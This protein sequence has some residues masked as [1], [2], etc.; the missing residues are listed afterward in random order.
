[1]WRQETRRR[2]DHL[3]SPCF[4]ALRFIMFAD[5]RDNT[6]DTIGNGSELAIFELKLGG[7]IAKIFRPA[8]ICG[9][10]RGT[11]KCFRWHATSIE[12]VAAQRFF[13]N[14]RHARAKLRRTT[15]NHQS[16]R[17]TANHDQVVVTH[18]TSL[19]SRPSA[20]SVMRRDSPPH[21]EKTNTIHETT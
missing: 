4:E 6:C 15:G 8:N 21:A 17:A 18:N 12:A 16:G 1:M 3:H 14:E 10:S 13:L 9:E 19:R 11:D 2:K 20:S 7:R 5:G